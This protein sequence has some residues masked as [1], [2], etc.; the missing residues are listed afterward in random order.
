MSWVGTHH[1]P[2]NPR[3]PLPGR[4]FV[5]WLLRG[6]HLSNFHLNDVNNDGC[7]DFAEL[8]TAVE[9]FLSPTM[10]AHEESNAEA[11]LELQQQQAARANELYRTGSSS[12]R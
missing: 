12:V 8:Q 2:V 10:I 1:P 7:I 6:K 11:A 9:M 3:E 5:D 4:A